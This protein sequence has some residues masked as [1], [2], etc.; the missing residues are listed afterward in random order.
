MPLSELVVLWVVPPRSYDIE[1]WARLAMRWTELAG[2]DFPDL[3]H[4][5]CDH[6][7]VQSPCTLEASVADVKRSVWMPDHL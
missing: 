1:I 5:L 7:H 4:S 6:S 2:P 3:I